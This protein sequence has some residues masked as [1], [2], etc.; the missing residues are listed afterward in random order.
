MYFIFNVFNILCSAL[1]DFLINVRRYISFNYYYYYYYYYGRL[2][3][4]QSDHWQA[5]TQQPI[6]DQ[7]PVK[8]TAF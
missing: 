6:I 7:R 2:S 1:C 4:V 3:S 5:L 8:Q